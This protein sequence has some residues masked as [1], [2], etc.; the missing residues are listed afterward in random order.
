MFMKKLIRVFKFHIP[1]NELGKY[2]DPTC[3]L[4]GRKRS[5]INKLVDFQGV[6][7][8]GGMTV[9]KIDDKTQS[10]CDDCHNFRERKNQFPTFP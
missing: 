7:C 6:K 8:L 5:E 10:I 9:I 1:T 3:V 4:C 2:F